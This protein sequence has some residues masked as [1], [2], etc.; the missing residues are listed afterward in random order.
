MN[1]GP[2][3]DFAEQETPPIGAATPERGRPS[4]MPPRRGVPPTR[5]VGA[6]DRTG[7][8]KP[9]FSLDIGS[10]IVPA[11]KR[12]PWLIVGAVLGTALGAY[13][14]LT[15]FQQ[16]YSAT[17]KLERFVPPMATD[18]YKP[19]AMTVPTLVHMIMSPDF[20][21][22]VGRKLNPPLSG[23]EVKSRLNTIPERN[24]EILS[25]EAYGAN[26]EDAVKLAN[27]YTDEVVQYTKELQVRD[28]TEAVLNA[29]EAL[30]YVE[31]EIDRTMKDLPPLPPAAYARLNALMSTLPSSSPVD[32]YSQKI[33]MAE[34]EL[35][36]LRS[37]YTDVWPEVVQK[38]QEIQ[39]LQDMAATARRLATT[40]TETVDDPLK[41]ISL[42]QRQMAQ[43]RI[44]EYEIKRQFLQLRMFSA[45]QF[46]ETPP[47]NFRVEMPAAMDNVA[48]HRAWPK[49]GLTTMFF[50]IL[51]LVGVAGIIL[52]REFLDN[53]LKTDVDVARVTSLPVI[54]T[55]G[56]LRQMSLS[57]RENWAFR[58]WISLQDRLAFSPNHGL[59]CG[60]TSARPGEGRST[61][62]NLLA[63]AARQCGFRV[64]T[65]ATKP[66]TVEADAAAAQPG[67]GPGPVDTP[68]HPAALLATAPDGT[69]KFNGDSEFTSLT[70]SALFTPAE[71]TE[72]LMRPESDPLVH[73]P[74]P[75]W[76]WN[77]ERRKQWQGAL[78]VWRKIDNVVILVEL[79]PA[80][81]HESV[82]L[83]ANL[84]NILWLSEANKAQATETRQQLETL[85]HARCN[86]VGAVVNRSPAPTKHGRFSRWV[87]CLLP[88]VVALGLATGTP[89]AAQDSRP[90]ASPPGAASGA[91]ATTF[92]VIGPNHRA[93][94]QQRFTLGPG[95]LLTL[96]L[97]GDATYIREEVP[98]GPDGKLGYLEAQGVQAAG[99]T[100]DE[101]R[102]K[103]TAELGRVRRSPQ[104]MILPV[105]YRSK[106]YYVLGKVAERGAFLLDRPITLIEAIA[107]ARGIETGIA[108][109]D[110]SLVELADLSRA[111]ISRRGQHLPVDFQKLFNEGDLSQNVAIEPDDY[112]Y[113]P[114]ADL[115]EVYVLGSVRA[116]GSFLYTTDVGAV[117]AIS[118]RGGFTD[119]AWKGK[120]L[121]IR[122]SLGNPETIV[123]NAA[124][125]LAARVPDVR[126]QPRDIIFVHDRPWARAEEL[127][128]TAA[129]AFVTAA[130]VSL[131]G[132]HVNGLRP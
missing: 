58:T 116:P 42:E 6:R 125:V 79:P 93:P 124:D 31:A 99:L 131:T 76:T 80:S 29:E 25:V 59:I 85:R 13:L 36:V 87:G 132:I 33:Q 62:V 96:S 103:L 12:W 68:L 109:A 30:K 122:G 26:P 114:T 48:Q 45:K 81:V 123:V 28:A 91:S 86:L 115:K 19:E 120:I 73:I 98:I 102:E 65:I 128:D 111:F 51:G 60:I 9:T 64:L 53:R 57:A 16:S 55:L 40:E 54:A 37:K 18:A 22:R 70:A 32:G 84:P 46:K 72:K 15:S 108:T 104:V 47:G 105:A 100:V 38:R 117:A 83:A 1:A 5:P 129:S 49:I 107:R 23:G 127:L 43:A 21:L 82:L 71:V 8:P 41:G 77:L 101:L 113:L 97:F 2:N 78:N 4:S 61:W 90:A 14:G 112:I 67:P 56:D 27:L 88:F 89:L 35:A 118:A 11:A 94:W 75:G 44:R 24:T 66:S 3:V 17:A 130:T 52:S 50:G 69:A 20:F 119:R 95:D 39:A 34:D 7:A 106:K 92:S 63:G 10:L 126:L 74:L 110:R 121:V